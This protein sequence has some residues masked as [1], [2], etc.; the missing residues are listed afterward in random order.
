[1]KVT[2]LPDP[3][4]LELEG[5]TWR[6][7]TIGDLE[8][9]DISAGGFRKAVAVSQVGSLRP[10]SEIEAEAAR[11][12]WLAA[13]GIP[14]PIVKRVE[15]HDGRDWLLMTALNGT[16]C[17]SLGRQCA[18]VII[19]CMANALHRLHGLDTNSCPFDHALARRIDDARRRVSAGV[20]DETDFDDEHTGMPAVHLF[21]KLIASKPRS[22]DLVV[23][24]GDACL[25]NLIIDGGHVSG[26]IDCGRLGVA[27]R[28]QDLALAA[29]S[30][31]FNLGV[32]WVEP[33][34]VRYGINRL[35]PSKL[36]FYRL[37]DEFF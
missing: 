36:A 37:L 18:E 7:Q 25:P 9:L 24:H 12:R 33:F 22:E 35:D 26:F 6:L 14:C 13:M 21:E 1:M 4:R 16:D 10:L 28:Y 2:D 27:D 8:R 29:R 31:A 3:W 19:E 15:T 17:T 5:Y 34:F 32:S 30:I 20:V 23:T 11:L